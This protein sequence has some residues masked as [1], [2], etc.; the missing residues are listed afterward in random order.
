MRYG[1]M[2]FCGSLQLFHGTVYHRMKA[3]PLENRN[4]PHFTLTLG[5]LGIAFRNLLAFEYLFI[6]SCARVVDCGC[7]SFHASTYPILFI[8]PAPT[9]HLGCFPAQAASSQL[10]LEW[11]W[12]LRKISI[13]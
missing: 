6:F 11:A 8:L 3:R 9:Y 5:P 7:H 1:A 2:S 12:S 10:L 13:S 4:E